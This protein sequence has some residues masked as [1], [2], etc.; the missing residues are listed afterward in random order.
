VWIGFNWDRAQI[1]GTGCERV[2]C[3]LDS[4]GTELKWKVQGVRE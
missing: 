1:E 2:R 4:T 3:G